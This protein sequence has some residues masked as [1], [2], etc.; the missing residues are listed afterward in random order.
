MSRPS[1]GRPRRSVFLVS[2]VVAVFSACVRG[3]TP[4]PQRPAPRAVSWQDWSEGAFAQARQQ[5]KLLLVSLQAGW[6]HWCHVM[7]DVTY[8]DPRVLALL[9]ES[10]VAIKIDA[11]S[12]PDL[13]ERYAEFGW[14]ATVILTPDAQPVTELKGHREPRGFAALLAGYVDDLRAGRKLERRDV[15]PEHDPGEIDLERARLAARAQLDGLYDT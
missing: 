13:A 10:F 15:V 6:C 5:H 9:D 4:P 3:N 11:D 14:P 7:N 8:R 1:L 12:R 2:F